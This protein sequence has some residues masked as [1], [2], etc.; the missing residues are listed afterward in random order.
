MR[1]W[2]ELKKRIGKDFKKLIKAIRRLQDE[3]NN[4]AH[5]GSLDEKGARSAA[6]EL[7]KQGKLAGPISFENVENII[8]LWITSNS[9]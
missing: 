7:E 5:P 3:R 4:V 9:L 1:R 6:V 2:E 8:E